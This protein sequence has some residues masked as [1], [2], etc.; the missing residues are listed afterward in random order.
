VGHIYVEG[1]TSFRVGDEARVWLAVI[2]A[3]PQYEP[4]LFVHWIVYCDQSQHTPDYQMAMDANFDVVSRGVP[5]GEPLF[6]PNDEIAQKIENAACHQPIDAGP[7]IGSIDDAIVHS[8]LAIADQFMDE[9]EQLL[10]EGYPPSFGPDLVEVH[11]QDQP[12]RIK[13]YVDQTYIEAAAGSASVWDFYSFFAGLPTGDGSKMAGL[14]GREKYDC[15]A[16][17]AQ[18]QRAYWVGYD[19]SLLDAGILYPD[20]RQLQADNF[21]GRIRARACFGTPI[22][23]AAD[24][25][26]LTSDAEAIFD[27]LAGWQ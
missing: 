26:R 4:P 2:G 10:Q 25:P 17:V 8:A 12:D 16:L 20:Q 5:E 27:T 24:N 15:N 23:A 14:W 21:D 18:Q 22:P 9:E 19:S 7:V 1:P 11:R 13:I 3:V 6:E